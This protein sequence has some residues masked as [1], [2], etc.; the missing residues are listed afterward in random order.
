MLEKFYFETFLI[1]FSAFVGALISS[2]FTWTINKSG[3]DKT[4]K[5]VFLISMFVITLILVAVIL[6]F[7]I[8]FIGFS[9]M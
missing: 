1:V 3:L 7:V 9:R 6:G 4:R 2:L 5:I 8:Y